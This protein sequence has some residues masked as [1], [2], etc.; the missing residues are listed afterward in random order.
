MRKVIKTNASAHYF[1]SIHVVQLTNHGGITFMVMPLFLSPV[2]RNTGSLAW[3]ISGYTYFILRKDNGR[4]GTE[5]D[6]CV[7]RRETLK[8][9]EWFYTSD[10]VRSLTKT[11]GFAQIPGEVLSRVQ[12]RMRGD[13]IC[14][15]EGTAGVYELPEKITVKAYT[16]ALVSD[17]V[18]LVGSL[19][20]M[21]AST[22]S[23][24]KVLSNAPSIDDRSPHH[25]AFYLHFKDELVHAGFGDW[26]DGALI[27]FMKVFHGVFFNLCGTDQ[28]CHYV[29]VV[30]RVTTSTLAKILSGEITHWDD[31][32]IVVESGEVLPHE[33]IVVLRAGSETDVIWE[34]RFTDKLGQEVAGFIFAEKTTSYDSH[35]RLISGVYVTPWSIAVIPIISKAN[36]KLSSLM[37]LDELSEEGYPGDDYKFYEEIALGLALNFAPSDSIPRSSIIA[38]A[39]FIH[40]FLGSSHLIDLVTDMGIVYLPNEDASLSNKF[41]VHWN[42]EAV[43]DEYKNLLTHWQ[44]NTIK[45]LVTVTIVV[46]LAW[47]AFIF[48]ENK[49]P[50]IR[51]TSPFFL[52]QI[53]LGVIVSLANCFLILL[54]DGSRSVDE[55][56][57][58]LS[59][60]CTAQ[61]Y[62]FMIGFSAVFTPLLLK[63]WRMKVFFWNTKT[64]KAQVVTNFMLVKYEFIVLAIPTAINIAWHLTNPL[65][66]VR[67]VKRVDPISGVALET[68]GRC[69][70]KE[71][72]ASGML[73]LQLQILFI[74]ACL[75]YG[76]FLSYKVRNVPTK[77]SEGK[78]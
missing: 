58:D 39:S 47:G 55:S 21:Q 6:N 48:V 51:Y 41:A 3:P 17:F 40:W 75:S 31:P 56:V 11:H 54:D 18:D 7:N 28:D 77:F 23:F 57:D 4:Y 14:A 22:F 34:S 1:S 60:S 53:I 63:T 9:I 35:Q 32:A 44:K 62:L 27:D 24:E 25:P 59:M 67:E 72:E 38:Y 16:S 61:T 36:A 76:N 12:E 49:H 26:K 64:L 50:V 2:T 29:N 52:Y 19:Y 30:V 43:L 66:W 71:G 42:G 45:T 46:A 20:L 37:L 10:T 73:F 68:V 69:Q 5:G 70:T 15:G 78:W 74:A 13:L 33:E 65:V 8:Y